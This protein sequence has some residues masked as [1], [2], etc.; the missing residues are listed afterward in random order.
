MLYNKEVWHKYVARDK[1]K[2][3]NWASVPKLPKMTVVGGQNQ[4]PIQTTWSLQRATLS[5]RT[6]H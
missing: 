5:S 6:W 4:M 1:T 3:A 2:A